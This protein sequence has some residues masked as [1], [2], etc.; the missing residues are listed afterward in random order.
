[1]YS[2]PPERYALLVCPRPVGTGRRHPG[3][4]AGTEEGRMGGPPRVLYISPFP[5]SHG[6]ITAY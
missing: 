4:G 6:L 2:E 1:M 3:V 5:T